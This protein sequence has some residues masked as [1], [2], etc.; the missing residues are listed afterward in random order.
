M[1]T[2]SRRF[3]TFSFIIK[4]LIIYFRGIYKLIGNSVAGKSYNEPI[5]SFLLSIFYIRIEI[6]NFILVQD[7]VQLPTQG[8]LYTT[9]ALI[10]IA[11][12]A[13]LVIVGV[14]IFCFIKKLCCFALP[15]FSNRLHGTQGRPGNQSLSFYRD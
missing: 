9:I 15:C 10:V 14:L 5:I 8:N 13:A 1:E 11:V 3:L 2:F 6:Y 4:I 7:Q 12:I